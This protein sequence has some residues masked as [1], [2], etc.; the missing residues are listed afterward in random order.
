MGANGNTDFTESLEE[1]RACEGENTAFQSDR[2]IVHRAG[3]GCG[4]VHKSCIWSSQSEFQ[5]MGEGST[6]SHLQLRSYGSW[7]LWGE[8]RL[9]WFRDET[10]GNLSIFQGLLP[11]LNQL[12]GFK[13]NIA[14]DGVRLVCLKIRNY[15][16]WNSQQNK[17]QNNLHP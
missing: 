16:A 12:R 1:L 5:G 6:E 4:W 13:K 11:A 3:S 7:W 8:E 14:G 10:L 2:A 17:T 9:V 15:H